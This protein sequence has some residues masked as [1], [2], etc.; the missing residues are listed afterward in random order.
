[1]LGNFR[2]CHCLSKFVF[3]DLYFVL[4][5]RICVFVCVFVF[6]LASSI[7]LIIHQLTCQQRYL[8]SPHWPCCKDQCDDDQHPAGPPS[9]PSHQAPWQ[10]FLEEKNS[11]RFLIFVCSSVRAK[12]CDGVCR[13]GQYKFLTLSIASIL[14]D[15]IHWEKIHRPQFVYITYL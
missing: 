7:L 12:N 1:M 6:L 5:F 8:I 13:D 9:H 10:I 15:T 3:L 14:K 2:C 4:V 11:V